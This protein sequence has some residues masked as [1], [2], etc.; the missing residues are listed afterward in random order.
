MIVKVT[1]LPRPEKGGKHGSVAASVDYLLCDPGCHAGQRPETLGGASA[2]AA[3][4]G[5]PWGMRESDEAMDYRWVPD[6]ASGSGRVQACRIVNCISDDLVGAVAEIDESRSRASARLVYDQLRVVISWPPGEKPPL[7]IVWEIEDRMMA[8]L[9]MAEHQRISVL[10]GDTAHQH[11]HVVASRVHPL[12]WRANEMDQAYGELMEEARQCERDY[13]LQRLDRTEPE[14]GEDDGGCRRSDRENL[15]GEQDFSTWAWHVV[16]APLKV[17]MEDENAGWRNVHDL[18]ARCNILIRP[19]GKGMV[20]EYRAIDG[21]RGIIAGA[22]RVSRQFSAPHLK[23]AFGPY[24]PPGPEIESIPVEAVY[25]RRPIAMSADGMAVWD[26]FCAEQSAVEEAQRQARSECRPEIAA[27]LE[28]LKRSPARGRNGILDEQSIRFHRERRARDARKRRRAAL[29]AMPQTTW[30]TWLRRKVDRDGRK[31]ALALLRL[32]DRRPVARGAG[33]APADLGAGADMLFDAP[34]RPVSRVGEVR[35]ATG[36]GG[37]VVDYAHGVRVGKDSEG[38]VRMMLDIARMRYGRDRS[39]IVIGDEAF[40]SR[41]AAQ[42]ERDLQAA[43]QVERDLQAAAQVE[44]DLRAAV[45]A[46][47]DRLAAE[48][49]RRSVQTSGRKDRGRGEGKDGD[50]RDGGR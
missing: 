16:G 46:K 28:E 10:H 29:K 40:R 3:A 48:E 18:T 47:R 24:E 21:A 20:F 17:L 45:W 32:T 22:S 9:D 37:E 5:E 4:K 43:A 7:R 11:L 30:Q 42:E 36:D 41:A 23:A 6:D 31:D 14:R 44:R 27:A 12:T 39:L 26:E 49:L 13:E 19:A 15:T 8:V 2:A 34:R 50:G 35:Y 38:A 25:Y 33:V 1:K